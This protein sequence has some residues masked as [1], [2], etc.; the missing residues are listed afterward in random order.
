[1]AA[2]ARGLDS[3]ALARLERA[4][5]LRLELVA[6]EQVAAGVAGLAA[7]GAALW[8]ARRTRGLV[9]PTLLGELEAAGY[10]GDLDGSLALAE[11]LAAAP[12]RRPARPRPRPCSRPRR[13]RPS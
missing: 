13:A 2:A 7:V 3:Q 10:A 5:R 6:V 12:P 4:A 1:V 9:D 8:A 11:A